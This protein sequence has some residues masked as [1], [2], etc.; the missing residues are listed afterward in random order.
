LEVSEFPNLNPIELKGWEPMKKLILAAILSLI[1]TA[2][3]ALTGFD[4]YHICSSEEGSLEDVECVFYIKGFV[5]GVMVGSV[6]FCP[7]NDGI[8]DEMQARL[9][10]EK[11]M[12]DHPEKLGTDAGLLAERAMMGAFPCSAK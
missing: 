1:P 12:R 5:D 3:Y 6:P 9:I 2:S 4:L 8:I 7:P 10:V 11:Y